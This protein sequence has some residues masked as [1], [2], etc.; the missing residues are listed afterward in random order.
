MKE[1]LYMRYKHYAKI[2]ASKVFNYNRLGMDYDDVVQELQI[3]IFTTIKVYLKTW[4]KYRKGEK[5]RPV[6]IKYYIKLALLNKVNDFIRFINREQPLISMETANFDMGAEKN[7]T[8]ELDEKEK[9]LIIN[10]VDILSGLEVKQKNIFMMYVK[11]HKISN[12]KKMYPNDGVE[13]LIRSHIS[14]LREHESEIKESN[15]SVIMMTY[16]TDNV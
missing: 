10:D 4:R 13:R 8:I 1:R 15:N 14:Y 11:G 12:L 7:I 9:V 16:D 5:R 6:P 2:Y 3:K